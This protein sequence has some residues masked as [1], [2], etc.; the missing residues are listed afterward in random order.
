[1]PSV[2]II[3]PAF[4][5]EKYLP[6]TLESIAKQTVAPLEVI[7]AN[8]NSTDDTEKIAKHYGCKSFLV[9]KQGY[10]YALSE[11]MHTARGDVIAVVDADTVLSKNWVEVIARTFV[12]DDVVA[13]TGSIIINDTSFLSKINNFLYSLFLQV[14]FLIGFPHLVGFNFAVRRSIF[15]KAG[16]LNTKYI[17]GPDVELG[18]RMKKYGK[19]VFAKDMVD[20]PSM[21]R[22]EKNPPKT[23]YEYAKS[24]IYTVWFR[25]PAPVKQSIIR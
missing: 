16:G 6:R 5:E 25:R 12:N 7:I 21:R 23:F 11:G 10:V 15:E 22:W 2:S 1:M 18:L 17:M 4:N 24:Y 13:A 14:N 19:V 8:N 9:T 20:S 3:I